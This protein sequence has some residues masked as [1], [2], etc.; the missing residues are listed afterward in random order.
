MPSIRKTKTA[1]GATAVQVVQYEKRKLVVLKHIGSARSKTEESA[2][3]A[4]AEAWIRLHSPQR[5]LLEAPLDRVLHLN[6]AQFLG[7]RFTFAYAFLSAVM[8]H[9]GFAA[10]NDPLLLDLALIRLFEPCS[11]RRSLDLLQRYFGL[12]HTER[13]LYRTLQNMS[14]RK[15]AAERLAVSFAKKELRCDLSFVLYDVT[16]L[17]FESFAPDDLRKNGFSKDGKSH[18]PQIMVGLLV[19]TDG[20]PLGYEV[21]KGNT[22]EGHTMIPVV[23]A[24]QKTHGVTTL[25]VVADAAMLSHANIMELKKHDLSYIVGGRVANLSASVMSAVTEALGQ[26]D[27]KTIRLPTE[28]GDLICEFSLKRFRKDAHEMDKQIAKAQILVRK[29]EPGKRAKFVAI[30]KERG[31]Y[32]LNE[33]LIEKTKRLLGVKGYYTNIP[34]TI[35]TDREV[36]T[37]YRNLWRVEQSF[38]MA[39]TDLVTRPIFHHKEASVK[40]H[41]LICMLALAVGKY[42][43]LK[44]GLSLRRII[45]LIKSVADAV[46]IDRITGQEIVLRSELSEEV[47][48]LVRKCGVSY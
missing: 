21:F 13:T 17:Y 38:R 48:A 44:T 24:F 43:E 6:T 47:E 11:K 4:S 18:Q 7:V 34:T 19:N 15:E 25:T 35:L 2:L 22:F 45:E 27:G 3:I 42:M 26:Q 9:C 14:G 32:V 8:K 12:A 20:F 10:L 30:K 40:A 1:S 41:L 29:K 39:K 46:I 31:A 28:H 16:T 37:Q 23:K 5:I 33:E 36:I